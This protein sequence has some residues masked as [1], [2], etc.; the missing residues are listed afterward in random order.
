MHTI[1]Y[2]DRD[3]KR[4]K[5]R[6]QLIVDGKMDGDTDGSWFGD[7]YLVAA[8]DIPGSIF[9]I[10]PDAAL[11]KSANQ[12]SKICSDR[13]FDDLCTSLGKGSIVQN[14]RYNGRK[15]YM[16][17]EKMPVVSAPI[18][19]SPS[20]TTQ[21]VSFQ[22]IQWLVRQALPWKSVAAKAAKARAAKLQEMKKREALKAA[23]MAKAKKDREIAKK[24]REEA[25]RRAASE[26]AR[27]AAQKRKQQRPKTIT[28]NGVVYQRDPETMM[29]IPR[30]KGVIYNPNSG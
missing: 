11:L 25:T 28:I 15:V 1:G 13:Y 5:A 29:P 12:S 16:P 27:R 26:A 7:P 14:P 21:D 18:P 24:A 19:V 3:Q 6:Y 9:A 30:Y 23:Y 17:G 22:D 2:Y 4:F 8:E 20:E 10:G